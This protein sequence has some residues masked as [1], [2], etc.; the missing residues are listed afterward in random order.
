MSTA[1]QSFSLALQ[2]ARSEE[3]VGRQLVEALAGLTGGRKEVGGWRRG[4]E[5]GNLGALYLGRRALRAVS[6]AH[7]Y[8]SFQWPF[9]CSLLHPRTLTDGANPL[10]ALFYIADIVNLKSWGE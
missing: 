5:R 8:L 1:V 6:Q 4:Q 10:A 7:P 2:T 3:G 9:L